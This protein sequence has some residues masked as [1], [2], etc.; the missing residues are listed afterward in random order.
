MNYA[1]YYILFD[2][3]ISIFKVNEMKGDHGTLFLSKKKK[4]D[5]LAT[6]MPTQNYFILRFN[7]SHFLSSYKPQSKGAHIYIDLI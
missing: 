2:T 5:Q 4:S 1:Q 3:C 6:E 7:V